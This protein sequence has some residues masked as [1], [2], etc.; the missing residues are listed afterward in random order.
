MGK[1]IY[2]VG[3]GK[4]YED[5]VMGHLGLLAFYVSG[6]SCKGILGPLQASEHW[7]GLSLELLFL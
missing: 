7:E 2:Y 4:G 1:G 5:Y 6:G 3:L